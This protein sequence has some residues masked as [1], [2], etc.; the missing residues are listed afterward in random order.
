VEAA[1][2]TGLVTAGL[3]L[4]QAVP[5]VVLYRVLTFWL[6]V[7]PGLLAA[8]ALRRRQLL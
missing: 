4:A 5:A 2:A 3:P 7:P 8:A 6:L 1:M